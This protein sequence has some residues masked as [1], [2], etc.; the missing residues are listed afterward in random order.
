LI[1]YFAAL[2]IITFFIS[3]NKP[4]EVDKDKLSNPLVIKDGLLYSDSLP[5][6]PFTGRH[7]SR[8]RDMKIEYEVVNGIRE[9]DFITYFPN[10]TIQMKG[11]MKK[12][13][14]TGEWKYFYPDGSIET[15]GFFED[16]LPTGQW[17]WYSK[18]GRVLEEGNYLN[19]NREGEW[20]NYDTT[21]RLDIVR[22][23]KDNKVID[24]TKVK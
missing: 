15:S 6:T 7:K 8:M 11:K 21:G 10:D 2:L 20:Y 23:Y 17:T 4:H 16:D 13:K 3:C 19:G 22:V 24:S 18:R 14:N 12:N 1:K 9:G 5:A